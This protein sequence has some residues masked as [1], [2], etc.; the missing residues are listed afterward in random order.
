MFWILREKP[1]VSMKEDINLTK[2]LKDKPLNNEMKKGVADMRAFMQ[3]FM[4]RII[5]DKLDNH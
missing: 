5:N 3:D 4:D 1:L 2:N